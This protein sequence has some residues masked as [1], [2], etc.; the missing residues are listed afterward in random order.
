VILVN[1][2]SAYRTYELQYTLNQS[3]SRMLFEVPTFKTSDYRAMI[4]EVRD[5]LP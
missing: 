3:E 5:E 1:I 4:E 2:N